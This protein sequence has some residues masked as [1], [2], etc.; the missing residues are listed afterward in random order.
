MY[1][2]ELMVKEKAKVQVA[3]SFM[4]SVGDRCKVALSGVRLQDG[5][6]VKHGYIERAYNAGEIIEKT[7]SEEGI[8]FS[9]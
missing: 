9:W 5:S 8:E 3:S 6:V 4:F 1:C 2:V 7:E